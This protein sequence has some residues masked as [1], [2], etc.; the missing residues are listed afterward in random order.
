MECHIS[1]ETLYELLDGELDQLSSLALE[2]HLLGCPKCKRKLEEIRALYLDLEVWAAG[3]TPIPQELDEIGKVAIREVTG[4]RFILKDFL[5]LQATAINGPLLFL[6]YLPG[7]KVATKTVRV[8]G[9]SFLSA[10]RV[11]I[12]HSYRRV[13]AKG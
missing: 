6:E 1:E 3:D 13:M 5:K 8:V 10:S 4:Q 7:L 9:S 12:R 11:M 2:S